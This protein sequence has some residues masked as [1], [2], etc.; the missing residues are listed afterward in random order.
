MEENTNVDPIGQLSLA[1][2]H[3]KDTLL[4]P[5]VIW[6]AGPII[7]TPYNL[8]MVIGLLVTILVVIL[9]GKKLTLVPKNKF[10]H[11]VEYGYQFVR[12]D[13]CA[14]VIGPGYKKHVPLFA[15][16]FFFILI[17]NIIGLLPGSKTATGSISCTWALALISF[18][19]FNF[20]GVKALGGW[21][22]IK[23]FMPA[24]MKGPVGL[25]L[26]FLEFI[27]M[28]LRLLT[29]AVRLFGNMFAGHMQLGIF[30]LATSIFISTALTATD[31]LVG[32]PAV[33]WIVL[34]IFIYALETLIAFLQA[35]I[36]TVLSTAYVQMASSDH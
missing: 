12:D 21:G 13:M 35:Y 5:S 28:V 24:G 4:N 7:I 17:C 2:E 16:M 14:S 31:F 20:W 22:Y 10:T 8:F 32:L 1:A 36:F 18:V 30:A 19:Y 11:M 25:F 9:V 6:E 29:L 27:S 23:S 15:T 3:L 33:G 34:L 26:W